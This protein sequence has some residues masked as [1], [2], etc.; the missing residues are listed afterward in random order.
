MTFQP[1]IEDY[2]VTIDHFTE[3]RRRFYNKSQ[4]KTLPQGV[5]TVYRLRL[6]YYSERLRFYKKRVK[7]ME[8]WQY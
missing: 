1:T 3:V 2:R 7:L 4:R 8:K 6:P 5:R